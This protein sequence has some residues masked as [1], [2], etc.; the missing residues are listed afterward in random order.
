[1][2][3]GND[4]SECWLFV[5]SN[6]LCLLICVFVSIP[7]RLCF[8]PV[9]YLFEVSCQPP[10]PLPCTHLANGKDSCP[11][12][13]GEAKQGKSGCSVGT[14]DQ[15]KGRGSGEGRLGKEEEGHRVVRGRWGVQGKGSEWRSANG[16]RR[17]QTRTIHHGD[18]P[19]PS[20]PA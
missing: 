18:M 6:H 11:P 19:T 1:M 3:V 20:P 10:P 15:G 5:F 17:L 12:L 8:E 13:Y 14:T 9:I 16:R 2:S 4:Q 7:C